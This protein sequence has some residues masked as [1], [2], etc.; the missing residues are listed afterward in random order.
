MAAVVAAL[1][2][3]GGRPDTATRVFPVEGVVR[4][5]K[6]EGRTAVIAHGEI[7]GYIAAMTMPFRARDT[8]VFAGVSGGDR[9]AFRLHVT[10]YESWVTDVRVLNRAQEAAPPTAT[11]PPSAPET[12]ATPRRL[13][14]FLADIQFTNELGQPVSWSQFDGRA[15]G[16]TFFFTRCPVPE[17]CPRLTK[18]FSG[19]AAKLRALADAPTNWQ[20]L[21]ITFDPEF[22]TP[23]VLRAYAQFHGCDSKQ[24]NFLTASPADIARFAQLLGLSYRRED[25][26]INHDFRT[27]VVDASGAIQN[28]WPVGGDTT[29][30][31]VSEMIKAARAMNGPDVP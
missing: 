19:A 1:T 5:L 14:E 25:G 26:T 20:L 11:A 29:D 18:N 16:F 31:L 21:S 6:P 30:F 4:E 10:E 24:W 28:L 3:C 7:V 22:D 2:G 13:A 17:Y 9:I 12:N 27:V 8:N 23:A 15:V